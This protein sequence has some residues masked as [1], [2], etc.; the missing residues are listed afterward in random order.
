MINK[1]NLTVQST[2]F[3][4]LAHQIV[5]QT[6]LSLHRASI[7]LGSQKTQ[8]DGQLFLLRH[9]LLLKQQIVAF[10]IEYVSP[11]V[12][13][14]FSGMASTF[15]E[16]RDRG[17]IF[18]PRA[19]WRLISNPGTTLLP[20][21]IE[22]MLDAKAELDG[23]LRTVINDFCASSSGR[24]TDTISSA[25]LEKKTF[26]KLKVVPDIQSAA[27][28]EIPLLRQKLEE[29]LDDSR[30]R[31]TLL[32]AIQDQIV[33]TYENWT[34]SLDDNKGRGR[35]TSRNKGK[36]HEDDVWDVGTFTDWALD[37]LRVGRGFTAPQDETA[38]TNNTS[39]RASISS[40]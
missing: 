31:E 17:S 37:T 22:N 28:K 16:L 29:Y 15:Y 27:N 6:T 40:T 26:S 20:R 32:A 13:F 11:D 30:T 25:S 39:E 5:H 9:L 1:P 14:D 3:D 8:I 19:L 12:T 21:V 33:L 34:E 18:D 7:I 2:V 36:G 24:I 4:D 23:Q 10:D 38:S 35:H